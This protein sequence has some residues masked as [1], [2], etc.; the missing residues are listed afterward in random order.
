MIH[1]LFLPFQ[2][3]QLPDAYERLILDV[4]CGSQTNFVRNDELREAWRILTPVVDR[5]QREHIKPHPYPYGRYKIYL[6]SCISLSC[7]YLMRCHCV[8]YNVT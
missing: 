1:F 8:E 6:P 5:L 3:V 2:N 7:L 4:F